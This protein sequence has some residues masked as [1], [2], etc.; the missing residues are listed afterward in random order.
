MIKVGITQVKKGKSITAEEQLIRKS[1]TKPIT[2][3]VTKSTKSK[4]NPYNKDTMS[5]VMEMPIGI[6]GAGLS[7]AVIANELAK[8]G[9]QVHIFDPRDH[10]GGNCFSYRDQTT[11]VMV[12]KYGPHIFHTNNER[13]WNYVNNILEFKPYINRVKAHT[14]GEVFSLPINLHTINQFFKKQLSPSLAKD[15]IEQQSESS[16]KE[17]HSFEEQA[18]K[19]IGKPLYE[20]FFKEYTLKQWGRSPSEL[21]ASIL[22]RLPVRFNY[23]D[24]YFNHCYQGIPRDGYTPLI[25][26]LLNHKN[27]TI[28]LGKKLERNEII[29]YKHVFFSGKIDEYFGYQYGTL[30]YR[31][32][33]FI[34]I[35]IKGDYQ[36]AAVI[37]YCDNVEK[38]TRISEHKHFAPWES[39]EDSI[40][41][42]EYSREA[43]KNDIPYYPVRL[44]NDSD[45]LSSYVS[46]AEKEDGVTFV[47]RL[48]TYR[49]L[50]MDVTIEEAIKTANCFILNVT[51]NKKTP[52]FIY[53]PI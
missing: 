30:S 18:L 45:I 37:N 15:F 13:V 40:C 22:K 7:G 24:N 41:F 43:D 31:T 50:D 12:H 39:H 47:G 46:L 27:I 2:V 14:N 19:F 11:G 35:R 9:Y 28:H 6:A 4:Y 17:A 23:D 26:K 33:D 42:K 32:L 29:N 21:P 10:I 49:Y 38:F 1:N 52:S 3:K 34:P 44:V 48:G 16:I 36:G 8:N 51:S 25:E 5:N 53:S 20:A